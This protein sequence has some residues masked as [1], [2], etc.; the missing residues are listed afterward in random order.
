MLHFALL[1]VIEPYLPDS[2]LEVAFLMTIVHMTL[3]SILAHIQQK[4]IP[5][6]SIEHL[7]RK[8]SNLDSRQ[9][10]NE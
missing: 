1:G 8:F 9:N 2:G 6:L 4:Q 3:W 7:L 10:E 5:E